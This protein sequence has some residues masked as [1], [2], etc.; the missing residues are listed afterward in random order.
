MGIRNRYS[1]DELKAVE[2]AA[3]E[4][5]H[6]RKYPFTAQDVQNFEPKL[7]GKSPK[8]VEGLLNEL[9]DRDVDIYPKSRRDDGTRLWDFVAIRR[10]KT[11]RAAL[12]RSNRR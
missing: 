12:E 11:R 8:Y 3:S 5:L 4:I 6:S 2:A 9:W 1:E 7:K 10:P